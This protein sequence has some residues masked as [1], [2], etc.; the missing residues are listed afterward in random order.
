MLQV[1]LLHHRHKG[2]LDIFLLEQNESLVLFNIHEYVILD[3]NLLLFCLTLSGIIG[4]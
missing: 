3:R 2:L 1:S 4:M